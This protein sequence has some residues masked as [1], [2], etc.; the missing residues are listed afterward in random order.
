MAPEKD[1]DD[2]IRFYKNIQS[3]EAERDRE[4]DRDRERERAERE[5]ERE[6]ERAERER[7]RERDERERDERERDEGDG[8]L[9]SVPESQN[10]VV[11]LLLAREKTKQMKLEKDR[12]TIISK[13]REGTYIFI[14]T[15]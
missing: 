4:R 12:Q 3:E 10:A 5:R 7:E 13:S 9:E 8:H 6:R 15:V 11:L 14:I 1:R 2:L